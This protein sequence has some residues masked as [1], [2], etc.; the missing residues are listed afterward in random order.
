LGANMIG[1]C[2]ST[3]GILCLR[4]DPAQRADGH[5]IAPERQRRMSGL[6]RCYGKSHGGPD[7][8]ANGASAL[9]MPRAGVVA[10]RARH[11]CGDGVARQ[12]RRNPSTFTVVSVWFPYARRSSRS[13]ISIGTP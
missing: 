9:G 7:P 1:T 10:V 12:S 5:G 8:F 4:P 13:S 11:T 2:E 3:H 6:P